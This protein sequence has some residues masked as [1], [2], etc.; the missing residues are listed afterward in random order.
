MCLC[1]L[2]EERLLNTSLADPDALAVE[3]RQIGGRNVGV[4]KIGVEIVLFAS[5]REF[6]KEHLARAVF[7]VGDGPHQ[8]DFPRTHH[9][10]EFWPVPPHVFI[11][12]ARVARHR[13]LKLV[14]V[15]A[16][17]TVLTRDVVGVLTPSDANRGAPHRLIRC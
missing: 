4:R 1:P 13:L 10:E 8:V 14:A 7:G 5:H 17:L 16:S 6:R 11:I 2:K 15:A 12:P 3:G 9:F